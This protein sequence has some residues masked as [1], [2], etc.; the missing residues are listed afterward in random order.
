MDN[1]A[2]PVSLDSLLTSIESLVTGD[3]VQP[4]L[5]EAADDLL[6]VTRRAWLPGP[7][8]ADGRS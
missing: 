5:R 8:Y 4:R 7:G 2:R 1:Q 6:S 3:T